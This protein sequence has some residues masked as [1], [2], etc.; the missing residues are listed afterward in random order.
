MNP[1][2][3]SRP[4]EV[5]WDPSQD[6][7]R[8]APAI[9]AYLHFIQKTR[10]VHFD[11]YHELWA[12]S[13][14]RQDD[15]WGSVWEYFGLDAISSY[16]S[17][18]ESDTMPGATW[19]PGAEVNFASYL[20]EQGSPEAVAITGVDETG[21]LTTLT[22]AE[23]RRDVKALAGRLAAAGVGGGDVVVGYLPNIPEAVVAFLAVASL[24]ATWSSVGQ[25]YAASAVVDRFSQ[26][27]PVALVTADGYRFN[28]K[29]HA[30]NDAI[31]EIRRRLPSVRLTV[32][33]DR[34]GGA[35]GLMGVESW[36]QAL[37]HEPIGEVLNVPFDHPLWVLFSSGTTGLPKG[38]VHSHGGILL[39][40]LK[41]M[42]FHWDVGR[43][44]IVYWYT[45]PSWVMWNLLVSTLATGAGIVCF[46]GSP[47]YP[48]TGST[49]SLIERLGVTFFGTSPGFLQASAQQGD[50]PGKR[51]DLS[52]L[53]SMGSTGS[54]LPPDV[55]RWARDEVAAV[56][57]WSMSGG[58]DVAG[59]FAGGSPLVPVWAGELSVPCLG[60]AIEA[61]DDRGQAVQGQVGEMV[62]TRPIPS[63]PTRL[64]GD[65]GSRYVETY[66]SMFPGVW[67]Q[68][69]WITVTSRHSIIVHGR[70]DSTLNRNGIRMGSADIYA[71]VDSIP[72]VV[73]SL[74]LG[75][76]SAAG[77]YW[78]PLFVVLAE[79][80]VLELRVEEEIVRVIREKASPR[81]VPDEIIAVAGIP[82]TRTGKKL[83]VP[84]KRILQGTLPEGVV[85]PDS[86][87]D[88]D[89][90]LPFIALARRRS[91][92]V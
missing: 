29:V 90:L 59:A 52:R 27:E 48:D 53:R 42:T 37:K 75:V 51:L 34:V 44:D 30:R 72:E 86:V 5:L 11:G 73:E 23:L 26:L 12:W 67:R 74:V 83:E 78:M 6:A 36:S 77:G 40:S 56:P 84:L 2:A 68:G 24:G 63:M 3:C 79:G 64:W 21:Q 14:E 20:L 7:K 49:W 8:P 91:G 65:D 41:Q 35:D 32:M 57:L 87:D 15:F 38:L 17:V 22:R 47:T 43:D 85:N 45:S 60:V 62:I 82:H 19:F 92:D 89:L 81:H 33:V 58:T 18:L 28:G 71:A 31:D 70:S 50:R 25:D 66:F 39:E 46:D 69:D 1:S 54:P 13:V 10:G 16:T 76:E 61:W 4:V 9:E 80:V 88:P 55:H